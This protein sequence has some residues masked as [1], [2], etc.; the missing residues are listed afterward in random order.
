VHNV[1][2][3]YFWFRS[4]L[5]WHARQRFIP[6]GGN[7]VFTRTPVL[8]AVDGWDPDCLAEDCELGVRLSSLGAQT[9]VFYEPELVTREECPPTLR[10]FVRQRTRWNQ[11][12]LQ[13]LSRGYWRRLPLRQ[14]TLGV[15]LL[16][17]PFALAVAWLVIPVAIGTAVSLK[18]PV[19][20]TLI[21]FLPALPVLAMLV[22]DVA[23]LG[24][25][26][27]VYRERASIRDYA[28]L[29]L[30]LPFYQTVLSFAAARAVA[31]EARG[32]R[33]WEK[34]T[35][36]GLH[37]DQEA[38]AVVSW[39]DPPSAA[40][41]AA[42]S[43]IASV[44]A[45]QAGP[46]RNAS[47]VDLQDG[48]GAGG[49]GNGRPGRPG[50]RHGGGTE[51]LWARLGG[52][53]IPPSGGGP[54]RFRHVRAGCSAARRIVW[55]RLTAARADLAVMVPL[56]AVLGFV[57]ATNMLHWPA[58]LFDEGTY[59]GNAWAVGNRGVLAFYTYTYGHPP[60]AW[61]FIA[62]WTS[63]RGLFGNGTYSLGSARELMCVVS[64]ISF[65]LL[66][67]L[68]RRMRMSRALA[69]AGTALFALS[70]LSLYFHRGVLLDNP[71]TAWA[72][73]AFV[74]AM[75]P[76][77]RL[78]SFAGSGVCFAA[79]Y[80][81]KETTLVLFPA[82]LLAA[83]QN[84]DRRTRR[85]CLALFLA[86]LALVALAY[87]LYATLKGEM[88]PGPGHV[89]LLGTDV[90][91][92]FTRQGTGSIFDPH[93]VGHGTVT[94]WLGLD[95]WLV[96]VAL[97]FSPVGLA[98]RTTRAVTAAYLI[99]V[100][101]VVR[102]GYLPAMYVIAMLP[103]AA[104]VVTGSIQEMWRLVTGRRTTPQPSPGAA[105]WRR[106]LARAAR[107]VRPV[108]VAGS[109]AGILA[110]AT[111]A[112]D[113]APRWAHADRAAMTVPLDGPELGAQRWLLR[114]AGHHERLIVT[115]DFWIYLIEHGFDSHP[116]KG[117]FNSPTVVSYWPLDKDPAVRRFFPEGWRQ[118]NYVVVTS[119]MRDTA[120][121][122]PSTYQALQHSRLAAAFGTGDERIE[123]RAITPTPV[124]P[125]IRPPTGGRT[126]H[127][128]LA[129]PTPSL[130]RVAADLRVSSQHLIDRTNEYPDPP[131]W[132]NYEARHRFGARLPPGTVLHYL[133]G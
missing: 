53:P 15:Y 18:A 130:R 46:R 109:V 92:L 25:F 132:W 76:R 12:Y 97:A 33:S 61:L 31:R 41:T 111:I 20:I 22:V 51:P 106:L 125:G 117:G 16:A 101:I 131:A 71:A 113:I 79:S 48:S 90:N 100:L 108:A 10:A 13:T 66:Y 70:P 119:A 62:L 121:Y 87:P 57:Q 77:R 52:D 32:V 55:A 43:L 99:Q 123:I 127:V 86:F 115:D 17:M 29:V 81:S 56:L 37:I 45:A 60:L 6:L 129:G 68:A 89:S 40:S 116:E 2:E 14:R 83:V 120:K 34:T 24:E 114:H 5:H 72:M 84:T 67:V 28:R 63:V 95:P 105:R 122:T 26:C 75:S 124:R 85:Y 82:L 42:P 35:H 65:A 8:R 126:Y 128:P 98:F 107:L 69:A 103:F 1:L 11:G 93:S 44:G 133:T 58:T 96:G 91:M 94:F 3:Y 7:T 112:L 64:I 73:A 30:G 21:S 38:M 19:E 50:Q 47:P 80:L 23:G 118:F 102:P 4:R 88:L 74:L 54:V 59:V 78:W 104:L 39:H 27:R 110:T 49:S 9:V 36:L